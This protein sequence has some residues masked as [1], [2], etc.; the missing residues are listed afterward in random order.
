M[1]V[2]P[3]ASCLLAWPPVRAYLPAGG[4]PV[5]GLPRCLNRTTL[6]DVT[7]SSGDEGCYGYP[8]TDARSDAVDVLQPCAV[9]IR[10]RYS[11]QMGHYHSQAPF[12]QSVTHP[13]SFPFLHLPQ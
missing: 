11:G 2:G 5:P 12:N 4:P 3:S 6:K 13:F 9:G 7:D 10:V 1:H 8:K